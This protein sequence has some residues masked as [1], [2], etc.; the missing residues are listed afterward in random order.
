M[1]K[2]S[3]ATSQEQLK[4][5]E[6]LADNIWREHYTPIIGKDQVD[7]MLEKFQSVNSM[8]SQIDEGYS[9]YLVHKN[10]NPVG[11]FSIQ[12]RDNTMFLS[13][14][15]VLKSYRGQGLGKASMDYIHQ[16]TRSMGCTKISLT[17][18]RHNK[19]T[20]RAYSALGFENVGEKVADIGNGFVMDDYL[21]E[22]NI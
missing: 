3:L 20:I 6:T 11:Y 1:I 19:N 12:K 8:K 4:Q 13:K 15:Y 2:I 22:K 5:I 18:N 17:V 7:Y 9:Y 21:L 14:L 10:D 16:K